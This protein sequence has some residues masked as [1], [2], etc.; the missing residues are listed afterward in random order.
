MDNIKDKY[1]YIG[2]FH[3]GVAIVVKDSLYGAIL[4]GGYEI[5]LPIYDYISPFKDGYAQAIRK[6]ECRILDLSGRECERYNEKLIAT[7][8][9]YDEVREFKD[10]YACVKLNGLWGAIDMHGNEIFEPQF[11]YLSD[12]ISGVAKFKKE[13][14]RVCNSWGYVHAS[15]FCSE[16]NMH[17]PIIEEDG[18]IVVKKL[19]TSGEETFMLNDRVLTSYIYSKEETVRINYRGQLV[20]KND[21]AKV[22]LPEGFILARDF[23]CGL[24][25]VLDSTGYWGYV[26][27]DGKIIIPLEYK[28]TLGFYENR[29][30]VCDK[31]DKW[32]LISTNGTVIKTFDNISFPFQF[33]KGYSIARTNDN[34]YVILDL[35]GNEVSS[36]FDGSVC[37][38]DKSNEFEIDHNGLKGYYNVTTKLFIEPRFEKILEVHK[39][40]VKIE[41]QNIGEVFTDFAGRAFI[42]VSPRIYVPDW[43]LGAKPL[44]DEIYL[45][46]SKDKKYGLID[47]NGETICEP[48]IED[49]SEVDGDIVVIERFCKKKAYISSDGTFKYGLYDIRRQVLVPADYDTRP[50]LKDGYYLISKNGLF[51]ILD[52]YGHQ[53]LKPEWKSITPVDDCFLV[54]KTYEQLGLVSKSGSVLIKPEY[55][56]I[57]VLCPGIYKAKSRDR[58]TVWKEIWEIYDENGKL[59]EGPFDEVSLDGDTFIVR[60]DGRYGRLDKRGKKIVLSEDGTYVELPSKFRWGSDFKDGVAMVDVF[61]KVKYQN[62]V[63]T[64]FNIVINENDS[65]VNV[66]ENVDYIYERNRYGI[67][68][69]VSGYKC[70][71]LSSEG[72]ILVKAGYDNIRAI[73]E[74]LYIASIKDGFN[75]KSGVI[76]GNGNVLIDIQYYY[77]EPFY[78]RGRVVHS[79]ICPNIKIELED[80]EIPEKIEHFL[81]YIY[82]YGLG[83]IDLK[84]YVCIQPGY[85]EIQKTEYGFILKKGNKYGYAALDYSILCEPKY[86][87]IEEVGNGFKKVSVSTSFGLR[88]GV[89]DQS[90]KECLKPIYNSIGNMNEDGEADIIVHGMKN[91][92]IDSNYNI[93]KKPCAEISD[94]KFGYTICRHEFAAEGLCWIRDI[95]TDKIGLAT[96]DGKILITPQYGKVEPFVNGYAKVNTGYWH[97]VKEYDED[98]IPHWKYSRR[99]ADGKWG[100][101]DILGQIVLPAEYSSIQIEE[102]GTFK[103]FSGGHFG[104][105][106]KDGELIVK[107][108]TGDY[109][110]ALPKYDW[111][112]DFDT[113]G[114]SEV[115]YKGKV[116]VVND[117]FQLI[118]PSDKSGSENDIVIPEEYDWWNDFVNG[119]IVVVDKEGKS[120]IINTEGNIV[121]EPIYELIRVYRKDDKVLFLCGSTLVDAYGNI[122]AGAS[123]IDITL[124]NDN[125]FVAKTEQNKYAILDYNGL[126]ITEELFDAVHD[127]DI[128]TTI[129]PRNYCDKPQKIENQKY[130][131]VGTDGSYGLIDRKG[132]LVI[133]PK[134]KSIT[135]LENG[136]FY[137][138]GVLYDVNE[139]RVIVNGNSVIFVPDGYVEAQLLDNGLI[140]ASSVNEN[141]Y[142]KWGCINQ[143]GTT[144]IPFIYGSLTYSD[145]FL[146]ASKCDDD[147]CLGR[148]KKTGVIN[149]KNEI[150]VPFSDEYEEFQIK[151]NLI[152]VKNKHN[153]N[154]WGAYTRQ[155]AIICEPIYKEIVPISQFALKVYKE[156]GNNYHGRIY[157]W[158]VI[159][160]AGNEKLPFEYDS[161]ANEPDNGLLKIQKDSR[162]GFI[163]VMGNMLLKPTYCSIGNFN[164]G[165]AIVSK[166]EDFNHGVI[167]SKLNEVIP[168][169]FSKM[170]YIEES[171][172]F[173]T[174]KGYKDPL[175][176]YHA[177]SNGKEIL[178]PSKYSYCESFNNGFA[179]AVLNKNWYTERYGLINDKATDIL[180]PIF[181]SLILLDNGLY[182]FKLNN[183]YGLIDN[184]GS[185]IVSNKYHAIGEFVNNLACVRVSIKSV[186]S[187]KEN[188]LYGY[189]D[190]Q[191]KELLPVE[192]EFIGKRFNHRTVVMK[193]GKWW[194]FGIE[195]H[196]LTAFPGVAYLGA[197][198]SDDLCKVNIGGQFDKEKNRVTGGL[199]GYC[200]ID[201]KTV[202]DAVYESAYS[203]SEG[204]AAVKVNGKWGFIN[205]SGEVVVPCK[206]DE[207]DSSYKDGSGRLTRGQD[208]FV[209]DLNGNLTEHYT[210]EEDGDYYETYDDDTPSIYDNPYYNDNIDMDQ[211]SIEFWNSF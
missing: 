20:V 44:T 146:I 97:N 144:I 142:P 89:I 160:F 122:V 93:I 82:N 30:F 161:I 152:L 184:T 140:L 48:V 128:S 169:H 190:V 28:E 67:Y 172:L 136:C 92:T 123:Y 40:Y 189:V 90:G 111:Q 195:D 108:T 149:F 174:E 35:N 6:G 53:I 100:I 209:F 61:P 70:G 103:V 88:Y 155:G 199:Y 58:L 138:N 110:P 1:D 125:F 54:S 46:I 132:K 16:S 60:S 15:G 101:I 31:N 29:A 137:G 74:D 51:G 139:K 77:L 134:Y 62:H 197:C 24:A 49:I 130:A 65:I 183:K 124:L 113:K 173:E 106:N 3:Q 171:H 191:G 27:L 75:M 145:V 12:F 192:Y 2:E 127:F 107:T 99:Y 41:V 81:I 188:N 68:T 5:I 116:G 78:E 91:G 66:D 151:E 21:N 129:P 185:I 95:R 56:E 96:E 157:K 163:D 79:D 102:D 86:A 186:D 201:G 26:N 114:Y 71:L 182:K 14:D 69:Y 36:H 175:G 47:S 141:G 38:T 166:E 87:S 32:R 18:N 64:S 211:Q 112:C 109:I 117:K 98:N 105:L 208:I 147:D 180:P 168:C 210:K 45:G 42:E 154:L 19:I 170:E 33:E 9:K 126:L 193:E 179:I 181:D 43:C 104:R 39:D 120:G 178:V 177:E 118:V 153:I 34:K 37:H 80:I 196:K 52:L 23:S 76:D 150:V 165:Y 200:S 63:D 164:H 207:V 85:N 57:V 10:G 94:Y 7:P 131:I 25:C 162:Y 206:Y 50:E 194:L 119:L 4:M 17:E 203:F 72:K 176:R 73:S 22:T 11:Y 148:T 198:V 135:I 202:I 59:T 133:V 84:G 121:V 156:I 55:N 205:T 13:N 204:L 187:N 8:S 143:V 158:G 115:Y 159:D 167:D 83:L